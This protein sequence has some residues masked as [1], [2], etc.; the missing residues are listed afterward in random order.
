MSNENSREGFET[1]IDDYGWPIQKDSTG[2][3]DRYEVHST[4]VAWEAWQASRAAIEVLMPEPE[5]F[6]VSAE[7]SME[8][9]PDE[10]DYLESRHGAQ[11][12]AWRK[13]KEA[14]EASGLKVKS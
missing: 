6:N 1:W 12:S 9:E 2:E 14:V 4:Q 10:Y 8:M 13:C 3:T 7:E 11:Y 5:P